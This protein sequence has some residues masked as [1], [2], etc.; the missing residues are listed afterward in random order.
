MMPFSWECQVEVDN[1]SMGASMPDLAIVPFIDPA[2]DA[3][4]GSA[5]D[6]ALSGPAAP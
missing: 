4:L 5:L 6:S 2:L 1:K 3:A